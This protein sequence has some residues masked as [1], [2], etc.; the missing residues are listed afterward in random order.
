MSAAPRRLAVL[1]ATGSI[2]VNTL[3]VV[4]QHPGRFEI[5][6]LAAHRQV[7]PLLDAAREFGVAHLVL[8]D[9]EAAARARAAAWDGLV[10]EEG[11]EALVACAG[12]P[13]VD[14]VVNAL[15]GAAGLA[16]TLA[17]LA[18]GHTVALANKE[19]LVLGGELVRDALRTPGAALL[20]VD[21]EHSGLFQLLEGRRAGEIARLWLTASGGALRDWPLDRLDAATPDDVLAHPTWRMG[22]RITVDCATLLNK[23]FEVLETRW[24]FDVPLAEIAVVVHAQSLVHAFAELADG[25][26]LAQ[27][28]ATDMRLPIQYALSYPERWRPP[29]PA[30][31][32][33]ALGQLTF[34]EPDA[35]RYP[36]LGLVRAAGEAGGTA[37]A[38]LNAADEVA[39]AA[40]L[41][42]RLSFGA[43]PGVLERVLADHAVVHSPRLGDI[44]EADRWARDRARRYL[45]V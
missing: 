3:D 28:S 12:R 27:I 36:C 15:V 35:A 2:G 37:P 22:P 4:R 9:A 41:D 30:V 8:G 45:S 44:E 17:A 34:A 6:A 32:P 19:S 1:G 18:A 24:L 42:G 13:D 33:L 31:S 40:F 14:V 39:V 21:S 7:E 25:S 26:L 29:A 20:P 38:V 10:V 43:L 16:P 5:V 11:A 23:G